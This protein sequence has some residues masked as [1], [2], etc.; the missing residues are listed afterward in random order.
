MR[1]ALMSCLFVLPLL[2]GCN[3]AT[4]GDAV[5][6]NYDNQADQIDRQADAQPTP[7]AK[8]IYQDRANAFREEGKDREKGLEGKTPS[9]GPDAGAH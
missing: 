6:Q 1:R 2:G 7:Q 9:S 3:D 4:K 5:R 8:K